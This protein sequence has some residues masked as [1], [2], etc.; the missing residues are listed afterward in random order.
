MLHLKILKYSAVTKKVNLKIIK[1]YNNHILSDSLNTFYN[2]KKCVDF[3]SPFKVE[4][5]IKR[6]HGNNEKLHDVVY[7]FNLKKFINIK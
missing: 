2:V 1:N 3:Q 5:K 6:Y 4:K 7:L